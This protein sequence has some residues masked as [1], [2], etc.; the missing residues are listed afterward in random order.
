MESE[1]SERLRMHQEPQWGGRCVTWTTRA[2]L[3]S[4]LFS[5]WLV[6]C[7]TAP[8]TTE[9]RS[10]LLE[11][12]TATMRE[13]NRVDPGLEAL[14]RK[15]HGYAVF[16]EVT[17][18]GLVFGGAYGRGVVYEQGKHI[19]Y[20]DLTQASF[21][22]QAGGQT[23]SE[24]IVFEDKA[25]LDRFEAGRLDFTAD[26]TAVILMTGAAANAR[27]VDGVTAIVRPLAGAMAE[28]SVGGQQ[29][30]YVPK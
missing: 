10:E 26:A 29:F 16:P 25:A 11:Q 14:A 23:Y 7:S 17:K 28:A 21:G 22:L 4:A 18:G 12:A 27:F 19:G 9:S 15:G 1:A 6:G 20:A 13:M 2:V 30:K 8:P 24:L 5:G 3:V